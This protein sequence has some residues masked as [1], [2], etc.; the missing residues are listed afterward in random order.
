MPLI[1]H[2][3]DPTTPKDNVLPKYVSTPSWS[4]CSCWDRLSCR[5]YL[6]VCLSDCS[7][8]IDWLIN[9]LIEWN[10]Y[11]AAMPSV[12]RK[13]INVK[14][15]DINQHKNFTC[16]HAYTLYI[17]LQLSVKSVLIL[18]YLMYINYDLY[19][20]MLRL[21]IALPYVY[22]NYCLY[23]IILYYIILPIHIDSRD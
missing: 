3:G 23:N 9:W 10:W 17:N 14:C 16:E 13:T 12:R 11:S 5:L 7:L 1:V 8:L 2:S 15:S 21:N 6:F 20:V 22:I 19:N 4:T 18:H